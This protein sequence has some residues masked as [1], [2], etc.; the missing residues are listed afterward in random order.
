MM[1]CVYARSLR[2]AHQSRRFSI[3][4]AAPR[5]WEVV[6]EAN[7]AVKTVHY[8]DWHRVE[9]AKAVFAMEASKLRDAGWDE[10]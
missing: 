9:R 10:S 5:G 2:K 8:D 6:D 3:R 4:D 1:A 7:D